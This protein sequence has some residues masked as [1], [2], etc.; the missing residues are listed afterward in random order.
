MLIK[1]DQ[2]DTI[3]DIQDRF[4]LCFPFLKL[5][6]YNKPHHWKEPSKKELLLDRRTFIKDI[7][8]THV[9]GV[10]EIKSWDKTGEVEQ[11]FKKVFGLN[12]QIFR[13]DNNHWRQSTK[14]DGLTLANQTM[15]SMTSNSQ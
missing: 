2:Q 1:I 4:S 14:S 13:R 7:P 8:K 12:A 10:L 11:K 9:P 15:I 3:A 5:E 6:F